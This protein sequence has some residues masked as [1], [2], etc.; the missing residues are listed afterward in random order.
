MVLSLVGDNFFLQSEPFITNVDFPPFLDI[1]LLTTTM[2]LLVGH[3]LWFNIDTHRI[4]DSVSIR[5]QDRLTLDM[6][7][8]VDGVDVGW[9]GYLNFHRNTLFH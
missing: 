9:V 5:I 6:E 3:Q 1:V 8:S 4:V 2:F 7:Y